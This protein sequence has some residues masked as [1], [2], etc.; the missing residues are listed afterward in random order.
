VIQEQTRFAEAAQDAVPPVVTAVDIVLVEELEEFLSAELAVVGGDAL[1]Q[2][3][4]AAV[5]VVA[6]GV[7]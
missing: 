1:D 4:D 5:G 7:C 3:G 2:V 6:P